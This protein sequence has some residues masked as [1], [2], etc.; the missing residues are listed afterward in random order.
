[1][2][3]LITKNYDL[4]NL[5]CASCAAKIEK[6]L[7]EQ[8]GVHDVTVNFATSSL[9]IIC[10]PTFD[11]HPAVQAVEPDVLVLNKTAKKNAEIKNSV[12]ID[13]RLI[14]IF[15]S[16]GLWLVGL[17]FHEDIHALPHRFLIELGLYG[18]TYLIVG[19]DVLSTG[20][21]KI[22][23]GQFMD[24][25]ILMSIATLG[26]IAIHELPEAI[27]VMLFYALG[28]YIQDLAVD[29]SRKSIQSLLDFSSNVAHLVHNGGTL[30]IDPE[31]IQVGDEILVFVGEQVP[32]DG[33][34]RNGISSLDT[35][36][37]TGES[38]PREVM[39]GD[40]VLAGMINL[41][42]TLRVE[43]N[44]TFENSA[45]AK[46][47]DIVQD[48]TN[49][50]AKVEKF[51]TQFSRYYTPIVVLLSAMVA[52]L[53]SLFSP[54][55]TF[56][57]WIYRG[58]SLL[59]ISCPCALVISIPLGYFG[60]L[61]ALSKKGILVK[62]AENI[63]VLANIETVVFDKTGTLTK[64]EF[65]ISSVTGANGFDST[66]VLEKAVIAENHSTHPIAQ[67]IQ[68]ESSIIDL[69]VDGY[70]SVKEFSG[71]GMKVRYHG[72]D[73]LAGN[74]RL[75]KSQAI[76]L[77]GVEN[78]SKENL[79]YVAVNDVFAGKI[80]I[81]DEIKPEAK[82]SIAE[83][84]SVGV[85]DLRML[86]GDR[87][88]VAEKI[89]TYLGLNEF[90]A[91][92]LPEN[93]LTLLENILNQK[94]TPVAYLGDGINDAPALARAD[95]GISMGKAGSDIAIESA[96]VVLLTDDLERLPEAIR[97]SRFTRKIVRENIIFALV[98]KVMFIILGILGI[99]GLWWAVIADVGVALIAILNA[100]RIIHKKSV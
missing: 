91:E 86:S 78:E 82:D 34:I 32:L 51:M 14:Q 15:I 88:S 60:G 22:L 80:E 33:V 36:A 94:E 43:V 76:K 16:F 17:I 40:N 20:V 85:K 18:T 100:S 49:R 97:L 92:L 13:K 81:E 44:A 12:Q 37:L 89:S 53:P 23:R 8:D 45:M 5:D 42:E 26:A 65:K 72:E 59:V 77:R 69:D 11:I 46:M 54:S 48:A 38:M 47:I 70:E 9:S 41:Q 79:L 68:K 31:K 25:E 61:G 73:I 55:A 10:D 4:K 95:V 98:A 56:E 57:E 29:S 50:K 99:T 39:A 21:K 30:D 1:M 96:D 62:G 66:T 19:W 35:S 6:N 63:D 71:M 3:S 52:F 58:L 64:G 83:L 90:D 67:A 93:K 84:R 2:A 27:G 28:E 7:K 87:N 24:E 74:I 75:M